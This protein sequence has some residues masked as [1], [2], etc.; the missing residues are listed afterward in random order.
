MEVIWALGTVNW[1]SAAR[2]HV[3]AMGL[4]LIGSL[5]F[6]GTQKRGLN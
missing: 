6:Q 2:H 1:G 5:A 3:P 4:L